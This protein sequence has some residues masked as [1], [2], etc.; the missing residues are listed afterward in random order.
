MAPFVFILSTLTALACAVLLLRAYARTKTRL[1]LFSGICFAGLSL[2]NAMV[3][4][5]LVVTP[6]TLS[7]VW[8]RTAIAIASLLVL[9]GGL[10]WDV[11]RGESR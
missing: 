10:V 9:I 5:D 3:F 2:N 7:L 6:P 4:V 1:L 8:L 11:P